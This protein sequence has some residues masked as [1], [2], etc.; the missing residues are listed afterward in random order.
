MIRDPPVE[1]HP[2]S[3]TLKGRLAQNHPKNRGKNNFHKSHVEDGDY[4]YGSLF[5]CFHLILLPDKSTAPNNWP[6]CRALGC[7]HVLNQQD[8]KNWDERRLW[9]LWMWLPKLLQ[10]IY[11][12]IYSLE[13]VYPIIYKVSTIPSFVYIHAGYTDKTRSIAWPWISPWKEQ[14]RCTWKRLVSYANHQMW[15]VSKIVSSN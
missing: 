14:P 8:A 5:I 4:S 15:M 11:N 6:G 10:Y 3:S 13:V 9:R 1:I 2:F 7:Q 12:Y